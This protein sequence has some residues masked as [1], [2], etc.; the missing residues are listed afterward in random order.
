MTHPRPHLVHAILFAFTLFPACRSVGT[1][2]VCPATLV[3]SER[4]LEADT[5][6][7][8]PAQWFSLLVR[9]IDRS[10]MQSR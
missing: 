7:L 3:S 5:R 8:S 1:A 4:A 6:L 2:P 9:G 10:T